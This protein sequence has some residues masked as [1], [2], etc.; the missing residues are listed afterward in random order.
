MS[1][2]ITGGI[3]GTLTIGLTGGIGSGKSTAAHA[4]ET[5]GITVI[6]ADAIAHEL[7]APGGSAINAIRDAFG[8]AFITPEGAL[9]RTQMR[10]H[11]FSQ[12]AARERLEAIL[13]PMIRAETARRADAATSPYR[14]LMIPLLVEARARDVNWRRRYDR[15]LVIDCSEATQLRRVMARSGLTEE[16]VKA[17]MVIQASREER[18]A[19]ADDV[20]NNDGGLESIAPQAWALH[21]RYLALAASGAAQPGSGH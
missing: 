20:I 13:H 15:I 18:L 21:Q 1:G 11:A 9:D 4:F 14:I 16:A 17:I 12:P 8:P 19:Q 10:A 3:S 6:D 5:H 2:G 7:T